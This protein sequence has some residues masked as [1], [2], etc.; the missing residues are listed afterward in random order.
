[1]QQAKASN[2]EG[3]WWIKADACD[4]RCGLHESVKGL[5]S[6]DED[7]GDGFVNTLYS[8]YVSKCNELKSCT[9]NNS[10]S[11]KAL[12]KMQKQFVVD[13]EFLE[14]GTT[15]A[16]KKYEATLAASQRSEKTLMNLAWDLV[17]FEELTKQANGLKADLDN[18]M[19]NLQLGCHDLAVSALGKNS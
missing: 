15:I 8:E 7:L 5:W 13:I 10:V 4:V 3:R 12:K 18:I 16:K 2:P 14:H 19:S 11:I 17:G 1:M 9:E 6:G